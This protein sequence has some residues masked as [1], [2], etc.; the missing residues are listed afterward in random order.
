MTFLVVVIFPYATTASAAAEHVRL[1]EG[2]LAPDGSSLAI[3]SCDEQGD[4]AVTTMHPGDVDT[5]RGGSW[6]LLVNALV[7]LPTSGTLTDIGAHVLT[8]RLAQAGLDRGFQRDVHQGLVPDSSALMLLLD[9]PPVDDALV[10]L[11]RLAGVVH[12]ARLVPDAEQ[13]VAQALIAARSEAET[14]AAA[15]LANRRSAVPPADA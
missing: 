4:F 14:A 10:S 5:G 6:F 11:R 7:L 13:L 15:A 1:V 2:D 8:S 12:V 9:E 3:V